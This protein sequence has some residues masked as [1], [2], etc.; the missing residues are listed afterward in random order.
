MRIETVFLYNREDFERGM[1]DQPKPFTRSFLVLGPVLRQSRFVVADDLAARLTAE[2][3]GQPCSQQAR[4][5][6][7]T[8][9][10]LQGS[11]SRFMHHLLVVLHNQHPNAIRETEEW[12]DGPCD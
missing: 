4:E 10:Q 6:V 12:P 3:I 8:V 9:A 2:I 5:A 1:G 11:L 7:Q